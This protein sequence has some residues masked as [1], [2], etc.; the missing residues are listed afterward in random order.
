MS[1]VIYAMIPARAGSERLKIKNLS[2]LDGKPLISYSILAAKDSGVFK[3]I[4]INSDNELFKNIS[5][6]YGVNFYLRPEELGGST[7]T[8]DEVVLDFMYITNVTFWCG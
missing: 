6:R 1:A 8:S 5:E 2:L 7:I 3:K 4:I